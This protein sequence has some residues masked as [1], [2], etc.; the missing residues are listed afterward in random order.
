MPPYPHG[1]KRPYSYYIAIAARGFCMGAADIVPGV[2][3]GTMA[4][5]LGIYHELLDSIKAVDARFF[6]LLLTLNF[7]GAATHLPWRFLLS[8]STGIVLAIFTLAAS[9][10]RQLDQHPTR[11][12]A[13]FFGLVLASVLTVSRN[14]SR[15]NAVAITTA[16]LG[17][18]S[19]YLLVGATPMNTPETTWFL[20]LSGLL[21]IVAMILPG[22]SGAYI[23]VLLGK[24]RYVLAAVNNRDIITLA[25]I[26]AGAV[27]GLGIF[28]RFLS[29]LLS[30]HHDITVA[31]L[32][33]LMLGSLRKVW[34]WKDPV[35]N[36][37]PVL[38]AMLDSEAAITIAI[39]A[40]GLIIVLM[41]SWLATRHQ[42]PD[43]AEQ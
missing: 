2:S 35:N 38:P 6:R 21:A 13:F 31:A 23:L 43:G 4:F 29:W 5:I 14:V 36:T 1:T 22:I 12:W 20:F 42:N 8:I 18:A 9:L 24:Y 17:L 27:L 7:K 15:W 19:A 33:G 16:L 34:P 39:G 11:V 28:A 37:N 30:R 41:L 25:V 10:E 26:V 3:G 32:S 40:A